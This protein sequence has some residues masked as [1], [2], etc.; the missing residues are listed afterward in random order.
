MMDYIARR[1]KEA[2]GMITSA[3]FSQFALLPISWYLKMYF[4]QFSKHFFFCCCF[5]TKTVMNNFRQKKRREKN[6]SITQ[7]TL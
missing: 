1:K 7:M 2:Q 4:A 3:M 5:Q 6:T